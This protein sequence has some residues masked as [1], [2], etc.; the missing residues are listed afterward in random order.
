MRITTLLENHPSTG[1]PNLDGEH[2]LSFYIELPSGVFMSDVGMTDLF[3]ENAE[4]LGIDL[5]L[6]DG[7]AISHH[8]FDHGGGLGRFFQEN[9]TGTVYLRKTPEI[10]YLVEDEELPRY[11]GLDKDVLTEHADRIQYV[12]SNQEIAPG[13]HLLTE[14]PSVYP[15]PSGDTR[16]FMRRG[17]DLQHDTFEHEIVTVLEGDYGLV[18]LTGCA[19]NGVLN[20]IE[21][22]QQALPDKPILAVIGGFHLVHETQ[23]VVFEVGKLLDEMDIPAVYTGH[24]TGELQTDILAEVLGDKLH[25]LHTGLVMEF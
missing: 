11:I 1:Q 2:G 25:R 13:I 18:L 22:T 20:M 5:S 21:A 3:A 19:H 4:K 24:C 9:E 6:V 7:L 23:P 15:K 14:I 17:D 12:N 16:L 10:D 8:H